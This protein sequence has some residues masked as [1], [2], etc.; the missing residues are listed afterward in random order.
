M[1]KDLMKIDEHVKNEVLPYHLSKYPQTETKEVN[2]KLSKLIKPIDNYNSTYYDYV[3]NSSVKF[4][5]NDDGDYNSD[6]MKFLNYLNEI[7]HTNIGNE[8][9]F[10]IFEN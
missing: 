8:T 7:S 1:K 6:I 5:L 10:D 3:F 4:V 9:L 2:L